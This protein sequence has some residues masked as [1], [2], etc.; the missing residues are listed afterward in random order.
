MCVLEGRPLCTTPQTTLRWKRLG[1][2]RLSDA[3][4]RLRVPIDRWMKPH[5]CFHPNHLRSSK[6]FTFSAATLATLRFFS[7]FRCHPSPRQNG[8]AGKRIERQGL[9]P[10]GTYPISRGAFQLVYVFQM[11]NPRVL[12]CILKLCFPFFRRRCYPRSSQRHRH[13]WPL[14]FRQEHCRSTRSWR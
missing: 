10:C 9:P 7:V 8:C 6:Y 13:R 12:R 1:F 4:K 14:D 5:R 2:P 11:C 3:K